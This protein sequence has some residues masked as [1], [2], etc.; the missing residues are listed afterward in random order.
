MIGSIKVLMTSYRKEHAIGYF[1][2]W[3]WHFVVSDT[4][5]IKIAEEKCSQPS[6]TGLVNFTI[7]VLC[8]WGL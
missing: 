3:G 4:D 1:F 6:Q 5:N 2:A 8:E 7:D